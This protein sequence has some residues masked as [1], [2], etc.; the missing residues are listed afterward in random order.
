MY[1]GEGAIFRIFV[2]ILSLASITKVMTVAEV[3]PVVHK[4]VSG[5]IVLGVVLLQQWIKEE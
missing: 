4:A 1:G 5:A 3:P 2:G